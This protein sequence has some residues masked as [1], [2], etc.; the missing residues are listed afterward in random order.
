VCGAGAEAR[1]GGL[2]VPQLAQAQDAP[3]D[4]LRAPRT[5]LQNKAIK[6]TYTIRNRSRTTEISGYPKEGLTFFFNSW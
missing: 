3:R 4:Q 2:H 1:G 5:Q 6:Y